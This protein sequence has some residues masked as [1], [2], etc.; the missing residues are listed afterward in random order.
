MKGVSVVFQCVL[1]AAHADPSCCQFSSTHQRMLHYT[2]RS[3]SDVCL[4]L[5]QSSHLAN[6]GTASSRQEYRAV[7]G[8]QL[9]GSSTVFMLSC[10]KPEPCS[11]QNPTQLCYAVT[12]WQRTQVWTRPYIFCSQ[13]Y[14]LW[15]YRDIAL[16]DNLHENFTQII[17]H[18]SKHLSAGHYSDIPQF[19][20]CTF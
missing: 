8:T 1:F 13:E 17:L 19:G 9:A 11:G 18:D 15:L 14:L 5:L 10:P 4:C 3:S 20:V 16:F 7:G 12:V 6:T 2:T